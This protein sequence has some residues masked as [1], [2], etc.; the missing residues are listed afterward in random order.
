MKNYAKYAN[1]YDQDGNIIN[2]KDENGRTRDYTIEEVEE[3]VDTLAND[4]DDDGKVK[5][6]TALN[7]ANMILFRLYQQ[8]GNPHESEL[9]EKLK[10]ARKTKTTEEEVTEKLRE[11]ASV[12]DSDADLENIHEIDVD[13]TEEPVEHNEPK[14]LVMDE[15]AEFEEI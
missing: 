6:P 8:Y 9:I 1:W 4:K 5:N 12:L 14:K 2:K 3:L 7:K 15:Y 13:G 11:V 10:E